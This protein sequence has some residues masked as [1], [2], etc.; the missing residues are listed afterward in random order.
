MQSLSIG[1][2]CVLVVTAFRPFSVPLS[3]LRPCLELNLRCLGGT[4]RGLKV[5]PRL[6]HAED[7]RGQVVRK[8]ADVRVELAHGGVVILP[9]DSDP[10]LVSYDLPSPI[11][12]GTFDRAAFAEALLALP[13]HEHPLMAT[14]TL[15][16]D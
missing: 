6:A 3:L 5:V 13:F 16:G 1:V 15:A 14:E 2:F 12:P 4:R 9:R 10:V 8:A 7:F 11:G